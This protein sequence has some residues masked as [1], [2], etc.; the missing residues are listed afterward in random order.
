MRTSRLCG[1][2]GPES[3]HG[4][5]ERTSAV[6]TAN[7]YMALLHAVLR[8]ACRH[9]LIPSNPASAVEKAREN[10]AR[11][12]CLSDE[13]EAKL[14]RALPEW[15]RPIVGTAMHTGCRKGELVNLLWRDVD[16]D[17]RTLHIRKD[18]AGD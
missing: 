6:A 16:L 4:E 8:L 14:W 5:G 17:A 1:P 12:R 3:G 11:N 9:G 10:N 2:Q 13:E 18:T 15:S 7:R